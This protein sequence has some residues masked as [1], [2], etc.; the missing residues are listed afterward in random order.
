MGVNLPHCV[1]SHSPLL[2]GTQKVLNTNFQ[3]I[4]QENYCCSSKYRLR[5]QTPTIEI[6]VLHF[7]LCNAGQGPSPLWAL[8]S[9]P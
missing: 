1:A 6:L 9:H 7:S 2:P 5:H 8:A 4:Y 3:G